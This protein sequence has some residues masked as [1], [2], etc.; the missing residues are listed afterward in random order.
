MDN[1][2]V[3]GGGAAAGSRMDWVTRRAYPEVGAGVVR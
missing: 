1:V 2:D 3:C